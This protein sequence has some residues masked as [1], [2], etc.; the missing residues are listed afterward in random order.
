MPEG[1]TT[2]PTTHPTDLRELLGIRFMPR[3]NIDK[4]IS[5]AEYRERTRECITKGRVLGFCIFGGTA[6]TV[7]ETVTELQTLS[8]D[9]LGRSQFFSADCEWG[10]PMRL[11]EGGTEFPD[12]MAIAQAGDL[13]LAEKIGQAIGSEMHELGILWN[14]APVCDVNSN[15]KNPIINTRSYSSDPTV[16]GDFAAATIR[17]LRT[18]GVASTAK[19][20]PGHGDTSVDSHRELPQINLTYEG[21]KNRELKP[22]ARAIEEQVDSVMLGH[23]SVPQLASH[24]GASDKEKSNP[25]TISRAIVQGLL[26]EAMHFNAV[27]VTDAMEMHAITKHYGDKEAALLAIKSGVDVILMPLDTLAALE[28]AVQAADALSTKELQRSHERILRMVTSAS[29]TLDTSTKA[30]H[31]ELARSVAAR[32]IEVSGDLSVFSE[33]PFLIIADDRPQARERG[34]EL[35]QE[36]ERSGRSVA[37]ILLPSEVGNAALP[38]AYVLT[39]LHR[40][41]GYLGGIDTAVTMPQ[42]IRTLAE[43]S[44]KEGKRMRG[45]FMIGSPY[46]DMELGEIRPQ[47]VVR[48]FSESRYSVLE[49]VELLKSARK[50]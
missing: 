46:L 11:R 15:P 48:T 16:A 27:V 37:G 42:A 25:A 47:A 31:E 12:A 1:K 13:A 30:E 9:V 10:L 14:F 2:H 22:F 6:S 3:L 39:T 40:A 50:R 20:F 44:L 34:E 28:H 36:L 17:G 35:Q 5:D 4:F 18:S 21:F 8:N 45:F 26:R 23:I 43:R 41:R 7:R 38:D 24:F 19:H 32:G 29:A 33:S 49:A